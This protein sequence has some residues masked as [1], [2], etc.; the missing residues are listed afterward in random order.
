M[1]WAPISRAMAAVWPVEP[2]STTMTASTNED[3]SRRTFWI[4]CSSLRHG[5]T[6]VRRTFLYIC[7][8][9]HFGTGR[10]TYLVPAEGHPVEHTCGPEIHPAGASKPLLLLD[11]AAASAAALR[12]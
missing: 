1:T 9:G 4:P 8:G 3:T 11:P 7:S 6:T 2:L 5:M 12:C 10:Y